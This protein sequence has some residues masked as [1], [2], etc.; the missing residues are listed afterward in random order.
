MAADATRCP[1]C[2]AEIPANAPAGICS[3]CLSRPDVPTA[4]RLASR[5]VE[6]TVARTISDAGSPELMNADAR[7]FAS[8]SDET[9]DPLEEGPRVVDDEANC[10]SV[11]QFVEIVDDLGLIDAAEARRDRHQTHRDATAL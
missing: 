2:G 3:R 7:P 11:D 5:G 8:R 10:I 1:S 9:P 4:E 6:T